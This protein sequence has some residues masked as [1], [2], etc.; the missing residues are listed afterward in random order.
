MAEKTRVVLD[1]PEEAKADL[2]FIM[3]SLDISNKKEL[4]R[5]SL[6]LMSLIV[7]HKKDGYDILLKKG[8][9]VANVVMP[10]LGFN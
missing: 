1:I 9:D 7:K 8:D 3:K 10:L 5:Y 4:V 2:D 6:G